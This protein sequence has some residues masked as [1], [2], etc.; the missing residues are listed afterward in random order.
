[1]GLDFRGIGVEFENSAHWSYSGFMDF[2]K[3]LARTINIP[4]LEKWWAEGSPRVHSTC[5]NPLLGLLNHS[6]CNGE[7]P[8]DRCE[9]MGLVL[10][11]TI[12]DWPGI[13]YDTKMAK[14]LAHH[15]IKCGK[16]GV[17][18]RFC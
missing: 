12:S 5:H 1:M 7:I 11:D 15:L 6:D 14:R 2:R 10:L 18:L 8:A 3:R 16:A 9:A 4:D 17:P 13:L